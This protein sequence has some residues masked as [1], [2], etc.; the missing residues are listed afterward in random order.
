MSSLLPPACTKRCAN[1]ISGAEGSPVPAEDVARWFLEVLREMAYRP[2]VLPLLP[3][4]TTDTME[5]IR[6]KLEDTRDHV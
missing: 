3:Q 1:S 6:R 4:E 5:Q 2:S